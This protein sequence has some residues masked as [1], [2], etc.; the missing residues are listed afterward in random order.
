MFLEAALILQIDTEQKML[1]EAKKLIPDPHRKF[2]E[3]MSEED[4][5]TR[6]LFEKLLETM[7]RE[8]WKN[9]GPKPPN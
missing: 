4:E 9:W 1:Q 5:Y 3:S 7:E 2:V 8:S 6:G